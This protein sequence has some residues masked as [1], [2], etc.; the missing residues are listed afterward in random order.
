MSL[1]DEITE[2]LALPREG[3]DLFGEETPA[4]NPKERSA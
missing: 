3:R 1:V 2:D 4:L